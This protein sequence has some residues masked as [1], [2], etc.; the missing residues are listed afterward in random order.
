MTNARAA[1]AISGRGTNWTPWT[2]FGSGA[3]VQFY[4]PTSQPDMNV[5]I[6]A[7]NSV[8]NQPGQQA[9][10]TSS[11]GPSG[12]DCIA[13]WNWGSCLVGGASG[14]LEDIVGGII[15]PLITLISGVLGMVGG[16]T[17]V[18]FGIIMIVMDRDTGQEKFS[19]R[20][21]LSGATKEMTGA[22]RAALTSAEASRER[23]EARE[24]L[25]GMERPVGTGE[26]AAAIRAKSTAATERARTRR[27]RISLQ[28]QQERD[29]A[30]A[31]RQR[32]ARAAATRRANAPVRRT[33]TTVTR[34]QQGNKTIFVTD[35]EAINNQAK[36]IAGGRKKSS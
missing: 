21:S 35:R 25:A 6:N 13:P 27:A 16:A 4:N 28:T 7:T 2:T 33:R 17:M 18:L 31:A 14:I 8:A 10:L 23:I 1:V 11:S 12:F 3:Y 29:A 19:L 22:E 34:T 20:D 30:I 32:T 24:R 36:E 9:T 15:N 5:P 26:R